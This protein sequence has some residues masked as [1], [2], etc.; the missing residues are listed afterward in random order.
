MA[1]RPMRNEVENAMRKEERVRDVGR[2]LARLKGHSR[3]DLTSDKARGPASPL[4][5][6]RMEE[7]RRR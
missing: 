4:G 6:R 1:R 2:D 5:H 7:E 3:S